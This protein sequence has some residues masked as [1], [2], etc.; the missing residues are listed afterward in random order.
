MVSAVKMPNSSGWVRKRSMS[1][2]CQSKKRM[3]CGSGAAFTSRNL[4]LEHHTVEN[5][6]FSSLLTSSIVCNL[7]SITRQGWHSSGLNL[8]ALLLGSQE[9]SIL[10]LV[11][12][13]NIFMHL[14]RRISCAKEWGIGFCIPMG[15]DPD[16]NFRSIKIVLYYA[17]LV[18]GTTGICKRV[19][20]YYDIPRNYLM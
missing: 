11:L 15:L 20:T 2:I 19:P 1:R 13:S 9:N 16:F 4:A 17:V 12:G 8:S 6:M 10:W 18:L 7:L 5:I 3:H 14:P